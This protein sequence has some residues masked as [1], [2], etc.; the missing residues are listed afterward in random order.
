MPIEDLLTFHI[1]QKKRNFCWIDYWLIWFLTPTLGL[2]ILTR[3]QS[4]CHCVESIKKSFFLV[5]LSG[6][7]HLFMLDE[8]LETKIEATVRWFK[9][10]SILFADDVISWWQFVS[11]YLLTFQCQSLTSFYF[12]QELRP[13]KKSIQRKSFGQIS[14][15]AN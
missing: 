9:S 13:T 14:T 15:S 10:R 2:F 12:C 6:R 5:C 8:D 11:Q 1:S 3:C 4:G 7:F